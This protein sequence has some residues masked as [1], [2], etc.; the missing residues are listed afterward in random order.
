MIRLACLI[1]VFMS[2][3]DVPDGVELKPV[4][5]P[6]IERVMRVEDSLLVGS[7]PDP[8]AYR[9]LRE[10]G[11]RVV[12][13]VDGMPPDLEII[14]SLGLRSVHLPIEYGGIEPDRIRSLVRLLGERPGL[15]YVHCHHG[16]H[17][18]PAVAAI[19]W[20]LRTG[21]TPES[22]RR[23][24]EQAGTSPTYPG[25][26]DAVRTHVAPVGACADAP[27]PARVEVAGV[28]ASMVAIDR[29]RDRL[30]DWAERSAGASGAEAVLLLEHLREMKRLD[31]GGHAEQAG[32]AV[33]LR[34][35]I[36]AAEALAAATGTGGSPQPRQ[37]LLDRLDASCIGCHARHRD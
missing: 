1:L 17:R 33:D 5:V 23:I 22:A 20:M 37:E 29:L 12:L 25:L 34:A 27:L 19:L 21:A 24:L 15:I 7:A 6:G 26:W 35:S 8:N 36:T 4:P 28:A 11:V 30:D 31:P 9:A 2:T 13:S 32:W 3:A 10:L 18:A 16:R 14:R